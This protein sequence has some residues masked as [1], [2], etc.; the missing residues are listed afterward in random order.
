[1][2]TFVLFALEIGNHLQTIT[3]LQ[4]ATRI[5]PGRIRRPDMSNSRDGSVR[6]GRAGVPTEH[7]LGY[8]PSE[9]GF[10]RPV[11]LSLPGIDPALLFGCP[12]LASQP[13]G[14]SVGRSSEHQSLLVLARGL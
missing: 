2:C 12:R 13:F 7:P 6:G 3:M 5:L 11:L 14:L 10:V 9:V 4:L 8:V 1:M